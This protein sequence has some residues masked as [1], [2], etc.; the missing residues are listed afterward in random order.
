MVPRPERSEA[1]SRI[2]VT[3]FFGPPVGLVGRCDSHATL[4]PRGPGSDAVPVS[5]PVLRPALGCAALA[6][7][8]G[9]A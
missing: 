2:Q 8:S 7:S 5:S 1:M 6:A 9:P 3:V 4:V